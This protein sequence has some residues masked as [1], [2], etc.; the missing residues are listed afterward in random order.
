MGVLIRFE[1]V[2][3]SKPFP[4]NEEPA[5]RQPEEEGQQGHHP[6]EAKGPDE[7]IGNVRRSQRFLDDPDDD[8]LGG[9]HCMLD[10]C[11]KASVPTILRW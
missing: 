11:G 7:N 1:V 3:G 6:R 9:L 4:R 10:T 2:P 5:E 8:G